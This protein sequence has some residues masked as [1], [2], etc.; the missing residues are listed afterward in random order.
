[1]VRVDADGTV[2]VITTNKSPF[3]LREQLAYVAGLPPSR[4]VVE[5]EFVGGDFGGKGLSHDEF[6]CYFLALATG[7]SVK[8]A[9][10]YS[11]E[12]GFGGARPSSRCRLRTAVNADGEI[13]A[14]E[15]S[16]HFDGG[17][18]A[19]GRVIAGPLLDGWTALEPYR[20]PNARLEQTRFLAVRCG[21]P[22]RP[23]RDLPASCT[24]TS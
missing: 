3:D 2:R 13:L 24:W 6:A 23:T 19:A 18:Y 8:S 10:S 7:R 11:E 9:M 12:L 21:H 4:I 14:H 22:V 15:S 17:A 5:S 1:V 16:I 20:V